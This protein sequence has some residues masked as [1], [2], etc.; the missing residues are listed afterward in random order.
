MSDPAGA[1]PLVGGP[2][3]NLVGLAE[4]LV[5][6][7]RNLSIRCWIFQHIRNIARAVSTQKCH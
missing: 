6:N 2:L 7:F 5:D 4:G 3:G 1:I